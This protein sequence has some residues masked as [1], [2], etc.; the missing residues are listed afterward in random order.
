MDCDE[1]GTSVEPADRVSRRA[2]IRTESVVSAALDRL[3]LVRRDRLVVAIS[4]G[5]DSVALLYVLKRLQEH[6]PYRLIAAHLN[7]QLRG[8]ESDNDETFVRSLCGALGIELVV[9]RAM[10]GGRSANLE[11]RA[12]TVRYE[13]LNKT[14]DMMAAQH[15]VLG[16]HADD[17]AETVLM[18]LLR[19]SGAAG[20]SAMAETGPGRL[21]RPLLSLR[22]E[23]LLA[24]LAAVKA[25]YVL[26]SSNLAGGALRNR[27]R[28][29]LLPQLEQEYALGLASR[30]TELASEMRQIDGYITEHA[31]Q[32]LASRLMPVP[33]SPEA[34]YL[35]LRS[36]GAIHSAVASAMMREM[37]RDCI[38]ELRHI[39]RAH[40][41]AMCRL[42]GTGNPSGSIEL[43]RGWRF[44]RQYQ[45]AVLERRRSAGN[46]PSYAFEL[47]PGENVLGSSGLILA[48]KVLTRGE[49]G[50]PRYPWH[51][52]TAAEAYV[53]ADVVSSLAVRAW[54]PG[55]RI[56][57]IGMRG[58]RKIQ[59]V[60]VDRKVPASART[61]WPV[62]VTA[63]EALWIP[64]LIRSRLGLISRESEKVLHL[65]A[66][67][68]TTDR[69]VSLPRLQPAC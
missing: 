29:A 69:Q 11:E 39:E 52:P 9:E 59:D 13:F 48:M 56:K 30:L 67:W 10:L 42:A 54:H 14:A 18:R 47:E 8:A 32:H 20:L 61:R 55:D 12:R 17:Q 31:R 33:R 51:P 66:V 26:D 50:F 4:G 45:A 36:F 1:R 16:H 41:S 43:P 19:G 21:F 62:V 5:P 22:R 2:I 34:W 7:H 68:L 58:G 53:D 23:A 44:R 35:D 60:F 40:I 57:P 3:K 28:V 24:Y 38:G 63:D 25:D 15:I 64:G 65:Q 6:S 49:S 37:L 46:Q 27:V